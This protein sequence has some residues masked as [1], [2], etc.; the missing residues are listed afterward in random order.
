MPADGY[1]FLLK[2]EIVGVTGLTSMDAPKSWFTHFPTIL[3]L[4][5]KKEPPRSYRVRVQ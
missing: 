4:V 2:E 5:A 3:F 1:N